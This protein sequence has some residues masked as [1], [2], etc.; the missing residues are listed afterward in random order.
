MSVTAI[1]RLDILR[2][3]SMSQVHHHRLVIPSH[4]QAPCHHGPDE[5]RSKV[6]GLERPGCTGGSRSRNA[7][8]SRSRL[9]RC[10]ASRGARRSG[11]RGSRRGRGWRSS[12]IDHGDGGSDAWRRGSSL[13]DYGRRAAN[14][15]GR[16][17]GFNLPHSRGGGGCRGVLLESSAFDREQR[18]R[19]GA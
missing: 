4:K 16:G 8:G 3:S 17:A 13:A 12:S 1:R 15:V 19:V 6:R 18:R 7:T 11:G 10:Q 14:H 5:C 2:A 9:L